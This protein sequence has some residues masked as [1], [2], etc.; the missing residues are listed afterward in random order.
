[1]INQELNDKLNQLDEQ[2][3][4]YITARDQTIKDLKDQIA[5]LKNQ[6]NN[7]VSSHPTTSS[8]NSGISMEVWEC[9]QKEKF[10][11]EE[12]IKDLNSEIDKLKKESKNY[13][14][15]NNDELNEYKTKNIS[16]EQEKEKLTNDWNNLVDKYNQL[17]D[18]YQ[19][20]NEELSQL[21]QELQSWKN[22]QSSLS[23]IE[24][25]RNQIKLLQENQP[26][27]NE[28]LLNS[29]KEENAKLTTTNENLVQTNNDLKNQVKRLTQVNNDLVIA[30]NKLEAN[31]AK[32]STNLNSLSVKYD[33]LQ[34]HANELQKQ[35]D[36]LQAKQSK[37]SS[38][39]PIAR[40]FQ[41]IF[42]HKSN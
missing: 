35:L 41:R 16:L 30:T 2:F 33:E 1:M 28:K 4:Q 23:E 21:K 38:S 29:F 26:N 39:N 12:K 32:L 31:N 15:A 17:F 8:T 22:N 18:T 5:I 34:N 40:L 19:A 7:N 27:R 42:H 6:N 9:S 3:K 10:K 24:S 11:L 25:L 36:E 37:A 13:P 20:Q 14:L